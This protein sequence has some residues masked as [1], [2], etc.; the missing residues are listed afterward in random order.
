V[1]AVVGVVALTACAGTQRPTTRFG[2]PRPA[3]SKGDDGGAQADPPSAPVLHLARED[4]VVERDLGGAPVRLN[5]T[6]VRPTH[7]GD[8]VKG[9]VFVIIPGASD[10]SRRGLRRGDG[11]STYREP[12]AVTTA[13]QDAIGHA[14]AHSLAYD[15]RTCGPN[16]DGECQKN[17]QGDLDERGPVALA[18]DVDAACAVA[19][20][21]PGTDGRVVLLAHGQGAQVALASDCA[22]NAAAVVLLSPV[23]RGIDAVLVEALLTRA[24]AKAQEAKK[25]PPET[26]QA[27]EDEAAALRNLGASRQASFDSMRSGKFAKDARVDGATI[28]FWLSWIELTDK[29][30]AMLEPVK[31]KAIVVVAKGDRQLGAAD[32]A[33]ARELPAARFVEVDADHHLLSPPVGSAPPTLAPTTTSAVIDAVVAVIAKP[34]S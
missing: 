27:Q 30:K 8:V 26:K 20:A 21:L 17:P 12:V 2:D 32:H 13:W 33:L 19:A 14:G 15:K 28:A 3:V 4:L 25:A 11:V 1:V 10:V 22:K 7:D 5:A 23:P 16:D 9:P 6:V 34:S 29:T 24:K 31:N 18:A